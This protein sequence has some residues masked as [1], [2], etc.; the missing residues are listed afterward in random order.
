M[1]AAAAWLL[2]GMIGSI[3]VPPLLLHASAGNGTGL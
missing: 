2:T 3:I 1:I